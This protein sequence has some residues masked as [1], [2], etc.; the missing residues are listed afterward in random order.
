MK[1]AQDRSR[2]LLKPGPKYRRTLRRLLLLLGL[3]I[4]IRRWV[5]MPALILGTSMLPALHPGKIVGVNNLLYRLRPPQ[6]GEVVAAWTGKEW[7]IKRVLGLPGEYVAI[8]DGVVY[9]GGSPLP[10]PYVQF[11]GHVSIAPG[12]I[13][14]GRFLLAGDNRQE[15]PMDIAK[16]ER[17]VGRLSGHRGL[18]PQ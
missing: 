2:E 14:P 8:R 6:R 10:E 1:Q 9:V 5:W 7:I 13:G 12:R 3:A 4:L 11:R 18:P 17:I 15:S 16:R